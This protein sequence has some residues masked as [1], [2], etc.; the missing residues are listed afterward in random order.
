MQQA[1]HFEKF[2][3]P[4]FAAS[5][6]RPDPSEAADSR[7]RDPPQNSTKCRHVRPASAV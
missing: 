1:V 3:Y 7:P 6:L 4:F 5:E 2:D